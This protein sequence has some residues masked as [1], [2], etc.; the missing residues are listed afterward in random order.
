VVGDAGH[1]YVVGR[2]VPFTTPYDPAGASYGYLGGSL[3]DAAAFAQANLGDG[4]MLTQEQRHAMFRGE[5]TTGE[6]QSYGLG[7]RRWT[8]DDV[9]APKI[10]HA[11][12]APG[13]FTSMILLPEKDHA[14]VVLENAF[15]PFQETQLLDTGFGLADMVYGIEPAT[16]DGGIE[17]PTVL[18]VLVTICL[19]LGALV[20]RSIWH[21]ARPARRPKRSW[22][23]AAGPAAWLSLLIAIA[24]GFAVVLP[25]GVGLDRTQIVLWVP[26][27]A[28]LVH[29]ILGMVVSALLLRLAVG[30]RSFRGGRW[31][32]IS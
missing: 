31:S 7:W 10:W 19:L 12:A 20:A 25:T 26:D 28:W 29:A 1:R 27:L 17:Y 3:E 8:V 15:G 21:L 5:V 23:I 30:A 32:A 6:G 22:R 24:S 18:A 11:G 4:T 9:D 14:I 13:F 2:T 16:S